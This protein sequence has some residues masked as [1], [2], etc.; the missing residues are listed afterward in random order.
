MHRI[1]QYH[2]CECERW[3]SWTKAATFRGGATRQVPGVKQKHEFISLK[4][5]KLTPKLLQ[6]CDI[7]NLFLKFSCFSLHNMEE[8]QKKS[9]KT[10]YKFWNKFEEKNYSEQILNIKE[11]L[12]QKHIHTVSHE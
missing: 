3:L 9:L 8:H 11:L 12:V 1:L 10:T 6:K 7:K 2:S 4:L 5:R